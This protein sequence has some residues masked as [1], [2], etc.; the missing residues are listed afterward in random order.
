MTGVRPLIDVTYLHAPA[1]F[2]QPVVKSEPPPPQMPVEYAL[3]QNYPNPFNPTTMIEFSLAEVSTVSL[4]VY[5]ILGQEVATLIDREVMDDG[6]QQIEFDAT[7]LPSGVYFYR[8]TTDVA[9]QDEEDVTGR[10]VT[11]TGKMMLMK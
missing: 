6:D 4:K 11:L 10:S 5:N 2:V 9:G 3:S 7:G 1:G 8:L